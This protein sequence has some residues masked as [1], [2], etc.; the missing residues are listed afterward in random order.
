MTVANISVAPAPS[1]AK[2][3]LMAARPK[4]L[5]AAVVPVLVGASYAFSS[6]ALR[7]L[8]SLAALAGALLL[9]IASNL[10]NDVFDYEKG[11]DG[12]ERVGPT[13][14]VAAGLVSPQKMRRALLLVLGL[15]TLVGIYL[16]LAVGYPILLIGLASIAAAVLY[17]AGP[18]PLG[19]HGLGD[20]FVMLF[21]GQVAVGGT[22][23]V[24]LGRVPLDALWLSLPVGALATAIL[25][26]NNV[27][28]V[29]TD[30]QS[31]KRTLVVR[32]GRSFGVW[33]YRAL[34]LLAYLVPLALWAASSFGPTVLLPW[35]SA[36]LAWF[37]QRAVAR[38]RGASLNG[39]LA[40][41][42]Q[43][44]LLFGACLALGVAFSRPV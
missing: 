31:G 21:F 16:I 33:E 39:T 14:V 18:Y 34:L 25:V 38:E 28:D 43:L 3:W 13:R 27:R 29:E 44:L 30:T 37:L 11:A 35:L 24:N 12:A 19:Y 6:A 32:F 10:A 42:A 41:T 36:P 23:F 7:P 26:V 9:Q 22:A 15:A 1:A 2:V 8:P 20:V 4:T 40:R 5:P 17:T